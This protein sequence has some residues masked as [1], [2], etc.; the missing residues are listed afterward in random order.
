M[1]ARTRVRLIVSM[2]AASSGTDPLTKR[3]LSPLASTV[4][5]AEPHL[6]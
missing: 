1:F 2:I 6:T 5:S 4:P 3:V